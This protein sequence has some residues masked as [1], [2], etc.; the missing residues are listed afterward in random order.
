MSREVCFVRLTYVKQTQHMT[1][2][3]PS[4]PI[5]AVTDITGRA[6]ATGPKQSGR[7]NAYCSNKNSEGRH[8]QTKRFG[9]AAMGSAAKVADQF[10]VN[11]AAVSCAEAHAPEWLVGS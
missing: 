4:S 6:F 3:Y 10:L 5:S 7:P 2:G 8:G 1:V 9:I 11:H